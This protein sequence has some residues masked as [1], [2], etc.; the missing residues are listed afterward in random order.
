MPLFYQ[1]SINDSGRLAVWHITENEEF[2]LEKV[3]IKKN[4]TH[5]HKR[6]QHLAARYL[7]QALHPGFPLHLIEIAESKKPFL[8]NEKFYFSISHCGD[9][10]AAIVSE[11]KLVGIDV[12]IVNPKVLSLQNKF[13]SKSEQSILE[14]RS[15]A[16]SDDHIRWLT[17]FW[18]AK[19]SIYK[20]YG[21]GNIDFK[22][23]M[24]LDQL[25][26]ANDAGYVEAYFRNETLDTEL[27][28]EF[29]FL[30]SLC[31]TWVLA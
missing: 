13:L 6:L 22:T 9:Y 18:S 1:H 3:R 25:F 27:T 19:E 12:E 28:V 11:N 4:I 29:R 16:G 24:I 2:F 20:W 14:N 7:L 30:Q 23:N 8:S 5:P 21:R 26:F 10:A 31:L 17:L 15:L